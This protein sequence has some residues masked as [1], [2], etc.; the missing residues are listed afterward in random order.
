MVF[1]MLQRLR[2]EGMLTPIG[3]DPEKCSDE[4]FFKNY[5]KAVEN[6]ILKVGYIETPFNYICE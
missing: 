5:V 2:T 4:S 3:A 6:G 1:E